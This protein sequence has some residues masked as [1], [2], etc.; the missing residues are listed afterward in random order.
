MKNL[1]TYSISK[2]RSVQKRRQLRH[3]IILCSVIFLIVVAL[4]VVRVSI[5]KQEAD[6][7]FPSEN[8]STADITASVTE[9]SVP[10]DPSETK[11]PSDTSITDPNQTLTL[12]TQT[13]SET[14]DTNATD[15]TDATD[16]DA[17]D[18]GPK[19]L[20]QES[21][22][23]IQQRTALQTVSHEERDTAFHNLQK[24]IEFLLN[25]QEDIR[26]GFY[27]INLK[28]GEAFGY[29]ESDPFVVGAAINMPINTILY[30]YAREEALF[31]MEVMALTS[32]DKTNGSGTLNDEDTGTQYYIRELSNL[33]IISSDNT[34]TAMLLRRLG[35]MDSVNDRL[36]LISNYVDFRTTVNYTDFAGIQRQGINR[37]S[38]YDLAMYAEYF[39]RQYIS[40]PH[41]YQPLFNDLAHVNTDW[42]IGA[43]LPSDVLVCHK[44]GSSSTFSSE[45][46]TAIVFA[47]EPYVIC[48][49]VECADEWTAKALQS[50]LGDYVYAYLSACYS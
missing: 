36:K 10:S 24:N 12:P 49:T 29:N 4:V 37:T 6:V 35:G 18:D 48:V 11:D 17:G 40:Y 9:L 39:Y 3:I 32:A 43:N 31:G 34:A 50:Q 7:L 44:T 5:M 38:A 33:S 27:Y 8:E 46:D 19:P 30:D 28:N 21:N 47:Y 20:E 45:T 25:E 1:V 15:S 23:Y 16:P 13:G 26:C 42:G 2:A 22:V 14:G 41:I